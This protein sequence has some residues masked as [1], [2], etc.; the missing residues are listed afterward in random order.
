MRSE[1]PGNR[2]AGNLVQSNTIDLQ[3]IHNATVPFYAF[4]LTV[5]T[6]EPGRVTIKCNNTVTNGPFSNVTCV[7]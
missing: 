5:N 4:N 2:T 7:P 3:N 6:T 1:I